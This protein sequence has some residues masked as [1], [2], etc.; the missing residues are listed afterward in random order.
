MKEQVQTDKAPKAVGPYSQ[1][2]VYGDL[3]FC[4]GQVGID[5][6]TNNLVEGGIE[7]ETTQ[8]LKNLAAVLEAAGTNK[9]KVLQTEIF[10]ANIA[11]Y[12]K[13]NELYGQFFN[14]AI[15]PARAT[16]EVSKLPKDALIE[17]S[18]IAHI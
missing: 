17:I 5:P 8:V 18:C 2:I 12:A 9:E 15:K 10:I 16:V 14:V 13:V 3:I 4:S 6:Q 7:K 1:A 11:D